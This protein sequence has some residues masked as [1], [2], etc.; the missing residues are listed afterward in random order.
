MIT[1]GGVQVGGGRAKDGYR[2]A[3][4]S[5]G[6]MGDAGVVTDEASG[7]VREN[8][9]GCQWRAVGPIHGGGDLAFD[10]GREE[11]ICCGADEHYGESGVIELMG[12][13]YVAGYG[14]AFL[15]HGCSGVVA[16][17][18]GEKAIG[19]LRWHLLDEAVGVFLCFVV[20]VETWEGSGGDT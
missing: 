4:R 7:E 19:S 2:G 14:P 8:G 11:A 16:S 15:R 3:A 5:R 13:L 20:P 9:Y 17:A 10:G 6:N 18:G 1:E 12:Y